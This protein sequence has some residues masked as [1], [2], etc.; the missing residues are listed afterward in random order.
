L[1]GHGPETQIYITPDFMFQHRS[2]FVKFYSFT[3]KKKPSIEASLKHSG[4]SI[5]EVGTARWEKESQ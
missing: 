1:S 4:E 2:D 3:I 5:R